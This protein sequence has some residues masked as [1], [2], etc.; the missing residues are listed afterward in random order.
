MC[1]KLV[2]IDMNSKISFNFTKCVNLGVFDNCCNKCGTTL[3]YKKEIEE[4]TE[5]LDL[6]ID[7]FNNFLAKV[8]SNIVLGYYVDSYTCYKCEI[9]NKISNDLKICRDYKTCQYIPI[10]HLKKCNLPILVSCFDPNMCPN[11]IKPDSQGNLVIIWNQYQ[12]KTYLTMYDAEMIVL[13]LNLV[14][15][16]SHSLRTY[17]L[18][19]CGCGKILDGYEQCH[20]S[21]T[22]EPIV[23]Q[24]R[25]HLKCLGY[26]SKKK[27]SC[28][29][30][31]KSSEKSSNKCPGSNLRKKST[32]CTKS[33]H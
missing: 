20:E 24:P 25:E 2:Q 21:I 31:K 3:F 11:V 29:S 4:F 12:L 15:A 6:C 10:E 9:I 17:H 19:I 18:C 23:R 7:I 27:S 14:Q 30:K 32:K 13:R 1:L 16:T 8:T 26:N 28:E 22:G 5:K 33:K